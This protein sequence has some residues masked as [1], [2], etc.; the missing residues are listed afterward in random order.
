M[1]VHL[2]EACAGVLRRNRGSAV[3]GGLVPRVL[4]FS[5]H[6]FVDGPHKKLARLATATPVSGAQRTVHDDVRHAAAGHRDDRGFPSAAPRRL[7]PATRGVRFGPAAAA[8]PA[9]LLTAR[10]PVSDG[11]VPAA[12]LLLRAALAVAQPALLRPAAV[13]DAAAVPCCGLV[14]VD[15]C[16]VGAAGGERCL[17]GSGRP[18]PL[19]LRSRAG[20]YALR[21]F[22][23]R[24]GPLAPACA[25]LYH[26]LSCMAGSSRRS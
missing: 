25:A 9:G 19:L 23:W 12:R 21:C 16:P 2:Q 4:H 5:E 6:S 17:C 3:A 10:R 8:A 15:A 13:C 20:P 22:V 26:G 14:P 18:P 11:V 24:V 7:L 1:P